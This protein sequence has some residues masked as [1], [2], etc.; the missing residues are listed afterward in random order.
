LILS[1]IT[2]LAFS[3]Y[4]FY[5]YASLQRAIAEGASI[6]VPADVSQRYNSIA[7]TF[8]SSVES[9]ENLIG[10]TRLRRKLVRQA[11]GDV[12]EVSIG[13]GRNLTFYDW[14]FRGINGV[15]NQKTQK[16]KVKSFTAVDKSAEM[17]EIAHEKCL[18][19]YPG[20]LGVRWVIQD[21]AEPLPLPPVSADERSGNKK[22]KKY[23]TIV[24]TMGLCSTSDPVRLLKNLGE[25]VEDDGRILL[26]EHGRGTWNWLNHILDG[27][28]PR[29]A[30]EFGCIW[31]R[32]IGEIVEDS[33]LEIV[34]MKRK[35]F[36][37]TWWIELR[38]RRHKVTETRR[39]NN[40]KRQ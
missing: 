5:L 26:L 31:N 33:G 1:S 20:V 4:S 25:S 28:A 35:H 24:Q 27:L 13:T 39:D 17:L 23:D 21:A 11:S 9:T 16:G 37:T 6:D 12:C 14:D 34:E 29:H 19:E 7:T 8:D 18:K 15:G 3:G 10:I 30:V 22:G 36:G 38:P 40:V 32:D 2:V